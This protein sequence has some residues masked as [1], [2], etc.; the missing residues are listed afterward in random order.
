MGIINQ[1]D[2]IK[3][4]DHYNCRA[5]GHDNWSIDEI[6]KTSYRT[7]KHGLFMYP[8]TENYLPQNSPIVIVY[9]LFSTTDLVKQVKK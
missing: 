2:G 7:N 5:T 3:K 8:S 1:L 6:A 4:Y 9:F